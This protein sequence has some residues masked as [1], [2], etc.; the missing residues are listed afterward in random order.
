M[1]VSDPLSWTVDQLVAEICHSAV[2]YQAAGVSVANIPDG[3][4]LEKQ[5]R[6]R[7]ITGREFLNLFD[8]SEIAVKNA[9]NIA[10]LSQRLALVN[11]SDLL[12]SRSYTHDQQAATAGVKS[13]NISRESRPELPGPSDHTAN[14]RKRKKV[15]PVTTAPV[16]KRPQAVQTYVA[17]PSAG[18]LPD[19]SA[20]KESWS[21]LLRWENEAATDDIVVDIINERIEFYTTSW[22]PNKGA[23]RGEEIDYDTV[24]MWEEAEASGQRKA[25]VQKYNMDH[26]YFRQRLDT[27]C[28]EIVKFPGRNAEQVRRQCCNLEVTV[29][30]MELAGWLRDIYSLSPVVNSDEEL[31][32]EPQPNDHSPVQQPHPGASMK[33]IDLSSPSPQSE[34][35]EEMAGKVLEF[36]RQLSIP[37]LVIADSAEPAIMP[38]YSEVVP[39]RTPINHGDEPEH[40]SIGTVRRW[41]WTD[42]MEHLDRKRV[43]SKAIFELRVDDRE[44]IRNRVWRVGK[45]AT[46]REIAACVEML[47]RGETKLRGVLPRDMPKIL[48][49]TD[50]FLSWWFC[51]NYFKG[52][53]APKEELAELKL[54]IEDGSAEMT[55]FYDY[56]HTVMGTTFSEEALQHPERP[57]QAKI[58]EISD[59]DD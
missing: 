45:I 37:D 27:L 6:A 32:D 18:F 12:R 46:I 59:D 52:P 44:L 33:I 17:G 4:A 41:L 24:R 42:L 40:A 20:D 1:P 25:L 55:T 3:A 15:T 16:P 56:V 7:E 47:W 19:A 29:E 23:A 26:T 9:L 43:V 51:R 38:T 48:V 11:V 53:K 57:S 8:R 34:I 39:T 35:E 14:G 10:S 28:D 50:L 36:R 31:Q 49:V 21:H 30:S 54:C 2:L 13:L 22:K 5:L 58:I